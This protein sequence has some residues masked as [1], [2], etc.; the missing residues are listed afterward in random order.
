MTE[1][2][3]PYIPPRQLEEID[4][5]RLPL[6]DRQEQLDRIAGKL[7]VREDNYNGIRDAISF[8]QTFQ[9]PNQSHDAM[10]V[11]DDAEIHKLITINDGRKE[12]IKTATQQ[13]DE[14]LTNLD[15]EGIARDSMNVAEAL[16]KSEEAKQRAIKQREQLEERRASAEVR[17]QRTAERH[18]RELKEHGEQVRAAR[19]GALDNPGRY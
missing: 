5:E 8:E 3:Q 7:A 13:T 19:D 1:L 15:L 18:E 16:I 14:S 9:A 11:E 10:L 6:L 4:A 2:N 12:K 17:A